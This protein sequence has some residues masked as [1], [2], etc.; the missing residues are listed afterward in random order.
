LVDATVSGWKPRRLTPKPIFA[1]RAALAKLPSQLPQGAT[2]TDARRWR[3]DTREAPD[4][5]P[6]AQPMAMVALMLL[7]ILLDQHF[8][9]PGQRQV[10]P[11]E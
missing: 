5:A 4:A 8:R 6:S 2:L 11:R 3:C 1:T 7:D 9:K 10:L